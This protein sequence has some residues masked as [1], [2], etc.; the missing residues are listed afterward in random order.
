M[1]REKSQTP[2]RTWH[3]LSK[4][5][6]LRKAAVAYHGLAEAALKQHRYGDVLKYGRLA[7]QS[8][9]KYHCCTPLTLNP[10]EPDTEPP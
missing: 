5:L 6:L 4:T 1:K 10:P 9:S 2:S 3:V 8:F 7:L